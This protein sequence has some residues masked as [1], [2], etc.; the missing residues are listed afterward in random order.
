MKKIFF[1]FISTLALI[2]IFA[3]ILKLIE[4]PA[5]EVNNANKIA[6]P[7]V[8]NFG[9]NLTDFSGP[10]SDGSELLGT[11]RHSWML[12]KSN[13]E[14][15]GIVFFPATDEL[16]WGSTRNNVSIDHGCVMTKTSN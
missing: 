1:Y 16:C 5:S 8:Q 13:G 11:R 9:F 14:S 7:I 10:I 12:I 15:E 4:D 2:S 6:A 3:L